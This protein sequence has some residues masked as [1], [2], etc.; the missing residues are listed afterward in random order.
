MH[1]LRLFAKTVFIKEA[2]KFFGLLEKKFGYTKSGCF[3]CKI[4]LGKKF[5]EF[6]LVYV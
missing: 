4:F 5:T 3:E 2:Q 6:A 1:V